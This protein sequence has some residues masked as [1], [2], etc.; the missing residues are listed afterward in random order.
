MN[1][2]EGQS[3]MEPS[4]IKIQALWRG[5]CSRKGKTLPCYSCGYPMTLSYYKGC[6]IPCSWCQ[7]CADGKG[8]VWRGCIDCR[9]WSCPGDCQREDEPYISCCVCGGDCF[10]GDYEKWRFCTRRCMVSCSS[11]RYF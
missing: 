7:R 9:D 4:A 2:Q 3:K 1:N 11:D 8:N 6:H 10:G 5:Y